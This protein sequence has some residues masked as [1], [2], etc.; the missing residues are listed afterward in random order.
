MADT[1]TREPVRVSPWGGAFT[2]GIYG[3]TGHGDPL[4]I[5]PRV[6]MS[7][8]A[9][10]AR[11]GATVPMI[12]GLST[13]DTGRRV[14]N[15]GIDIACDGPGQWRVRADRKAEG[16]LCREV[17]A[18]VGSSASVIDQSHGWVT[19]DISGEMAPDVLAKGTSIDLHLDSFGAGQ[20]A[21]TQIHHMMVHVTC[22]DDA[23]PSHPPYSGTGWSRSD[24][25]VS[26]LSGTILPSS[27]SVA[28]VA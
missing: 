4:L 5:T 20:C 19:V 16:E 15:T 22:L 7:S 8:V 6:D 26:D 27:L 23:G 25:I 9:V 11:D 14:A 13:P 18:A 24:Q 1:P 3:N 17:Q 21:A 12:S 28:D 10:I 2:P